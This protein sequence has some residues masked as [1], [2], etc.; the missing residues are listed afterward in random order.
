MNLYFYDLAYAI[1][2]GVFLGAL[3]LVVR[4]RQTGF[5]ILGNIWLAGLIAQ[6]IYIVFRTFEAGR[7]PISNFFESIAVMVFIASLC[8]FVYWRKSKI[9]LLILIVN[10]FNFVMLSINFSFPRQIPTLM[11]ALQSYWLPIHVSTTL[12]GYAIFCVAAL[13]G[14]LYFLKE[15]YSH[16]NLPDLIVLEELGFKIVIFGF[17]IYALGAL[18]FGSIWA[19]E[20]WGRYWFWDPKETWALIIF[21]YYA[22]YLHMRNREKFTHRHGALF[23]VGGL[24][25]IMFSYFG[26]NILISG[27]HSYAKN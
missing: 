25:F 26:V 12:S 3:F 18:L 22:V 8:G 17:P 13:V 7:A 24:L 10:L 1:Y 15:R 9:D 5:N 11:P 6:A 16:L 27:L 23:L 19:H 14:I 20:A 21:L 2:G 4:N